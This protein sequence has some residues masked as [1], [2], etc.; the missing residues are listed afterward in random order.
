M[1][2]GTPETPIKKTVVIEPLMDGFVRKTWAILI[3]DGY[4]A[5]YSTALN[6]MLLAAV[7]EATKTKGLSQK[8]RDTVWAFANDQDTIDKLNLHDHVARLRELWGANH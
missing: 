8:A 3:E 1:P 4:D 2:R 6:F 7:M 5:S